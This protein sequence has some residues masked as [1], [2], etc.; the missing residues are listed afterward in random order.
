MHEDFILRGAKICR[1][2][3]RVVV[4]SELWN[5]KEVQR[6]D[7]CRRFSS[8]KRPSFQGEG[9]TVMQLVK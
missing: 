1:W 6:E 8:A 4:L 5:A 3:K 7:W 2:K 9:Q